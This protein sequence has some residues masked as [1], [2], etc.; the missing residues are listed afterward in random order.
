[1]IE[2]THQVASVLQPPPGHHTSV[3]FL[4]QA[5]HTYPHNVCKTWC[6][7]DIIMKDDLP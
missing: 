6:D 5:G 1:M 7:G 2:R 4:A 3:V